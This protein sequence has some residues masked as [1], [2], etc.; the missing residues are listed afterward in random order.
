M[1]IAFSKTRQLCIPQCQRQIRLILEAALSGWSFVLGPPT[2]KS[3]KL[4]GYFSNHLLRRAYMPSQRILL[5]RFRFY[6]W[7]SVPNALRGWAWGSLRFIRY[8]PHAHSAQLHRISSKPFPHK[9]QAK[10]LYCCLLFSTRDA[11]NSLYA[12]SF[13][14]SRSC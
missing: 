2:C 5:I 10:A 7:A 6:A 8:P 4:E 3:T 1:F 12:K 14:L 13:T 9:S 11:G